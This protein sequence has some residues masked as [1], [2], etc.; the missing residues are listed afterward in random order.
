[1]AE[2]RVADV[3]T[4]AQRFGQVL[5]EPKLAREHAADLRDLETVR[6]AGAVMVAIGRDKHL[7]LGTQAA[8]GDRMDDPVAVA[9]EFAARAA[10]PLAFLGEFAPAAG[11]G[12]GSVGGCVHARRGLGQR[13]VGDNVN[14]RRTRR[15][16]GRMCAR[17]AG[18]AGLRIQPRIQSAAARQWISVES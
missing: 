8:E 5:V 1:M 10:R 17:T 11:G 15:V 18:F 4:Q 6:Q 7:R 3:V 9:L 13:R 12:I 2:G 14:E 16:F